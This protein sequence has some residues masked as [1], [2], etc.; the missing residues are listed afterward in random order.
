MTFPIQ[1]TAKDL[2]D[3]G[4][5]DTLINERM[6]RLEKFHHRITSARVA[7]TV[8]GSHPVRHQLK[9]EI[10]IPGS[11]I[12]VERGPAEDLPHAIREAFDIARRQLQ[13]HDPHKHHHISDKR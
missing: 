11:E 5:I 3:R 12:V 9:L 4:P 1:I 10:A 6:Q 8:E 7:I 13:D 2:K